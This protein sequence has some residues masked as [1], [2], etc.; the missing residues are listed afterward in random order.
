MQKDHLL[1]EVIPT[2]IRSLF[3]ST[4]LF[5]KYADHG[6]ECGYRRGRQSY[7]CNVLRE[8]SDGP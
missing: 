2:G 4:M 8:S 6:L 1:G 5:W 3:H 7:R